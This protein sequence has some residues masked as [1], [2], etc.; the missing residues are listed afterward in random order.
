MFDH[1]LIIICINYPINFPKLIK[2][3]N[4]TAKFFA[5][6]PKSNKTRFNFYLVDSVNKIQ[7]II[8]NKSYLNYFPLLFQHKNQKFIFP[9]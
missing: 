1:L 9:N 3:K 6:R 7:K 4:L 2:L 5:K 8:T